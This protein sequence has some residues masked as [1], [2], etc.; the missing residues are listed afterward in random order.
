MSH[1]REG[2]LITRLVLPVFEL[3]GEFL[4]AAEDICAPAGL[5]PAQW[6][7][8]GAALDEPLPVAEIARRV[9]LLA[10]QSVQ[11][12]ADDLVRRGWAEYRENPRHRRAKLVAPTAAGRAKVDG[13]REAQHAWS[14]AVGAEL[15]ATE[16]EAA[17]TLVLRIAE[18][19]RGVRSN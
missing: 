4:A 15:D 5:T 10:R 2:D 12:V 9:G 7:V 6:K 11:R 13:L 8:L 18:V 14:N 16:L 19:S 3:N 17:R 1:T